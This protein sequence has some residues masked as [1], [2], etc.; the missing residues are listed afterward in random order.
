MTT[1]PPDPRPSFPRLVARDLLRLAT[2]TC[3]L[4][5]AI[6]GLLYGSALL[7]LYRAW[8]VAVDLPACLVVAH[9][10]GYEPATGLTDLTVLRM[11]A[12]PGL[13]G[14]TW[15]FHGV[16]LV[17]RPNGGTDMYNW[18]WRRLAFDP[19]ILSQANEVLWPTAGACVPGRLLAAR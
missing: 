12:Q 15:R 5:I 16:L 14:L 18:S 9:D 19:A 13:G 2:D 6:G 10:D 8:E 7:V 3:F 11:Q 4:A 17:S 1:V